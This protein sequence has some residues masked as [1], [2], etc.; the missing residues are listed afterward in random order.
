M[1]SWMV[2]MLDYPMVIGMEKPCVKERMA[3]QNPISM[4]ITNFSSI[5]YADYLNTLT[6]GDTEG[7]VLGPALGLILGDLV[8]VAVGKS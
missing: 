3:V 4:R 8:G 2:W 5:L 6:D 1:D 7:L